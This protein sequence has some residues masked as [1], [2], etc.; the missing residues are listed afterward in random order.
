MSQGT[1]WREAYCLL[2]RVTRKVDS[3]SVLDA[4]VPDYVW[5][6]VIARDICMYQIGALPGTFF[7]ELLSDTEFLLFQDPQSGPGMAW[8]DTI[9]YI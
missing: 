8:E 7:V 6:E 2:V 9:C 5:T 3:V 4:K 1:C